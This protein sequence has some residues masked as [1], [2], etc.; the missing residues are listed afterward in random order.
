MASTKGRVEVVSVDLGGHISFSMPHWNTHAASYCPKRPKLVLRIRL[1]MLNNV[2]SVSWAVCLL[3]VVHI[4]VGR[5]RKPIVCLH[6][7]DYKVDEY[8]H[9]LYISF[10][11]QNFYIQFQFV[12]C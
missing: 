1:K 7:F 8:F 2:P 5:K 6:L 4:R 9:C 10:H 12:E 3:C 11:F